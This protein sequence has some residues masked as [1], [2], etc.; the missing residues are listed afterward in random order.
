MLSCF[1]I[2]GKLL[3]AFGNLQMFFWMLLA[4]EFLFET[5]FECLFMDATC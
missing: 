5:V 4:V 1:N 2:F 3:D